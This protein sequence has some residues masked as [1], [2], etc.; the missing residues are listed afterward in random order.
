VAGS[1]P[2]LAADG[3]IGYVTGEG[4]YLALDGTLLRRPVA[5]PEA[6]GGPNSGAEAARVSW[7]RWRL[8]FGW[9]LGQRNAELRCRTLF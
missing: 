7:G 4:I 8:W 3:K 1:V 5:Q 6:T 2:N 9:V